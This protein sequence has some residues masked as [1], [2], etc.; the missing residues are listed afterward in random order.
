VLDRIAEVLPDCRHVRMEIAGHT[1]SQG[2]DEMNLNLSQSRANA[3]LNGLLARNVLVS[4]L[5]AQ[6]YGETQP[7]AS[8]ETESGREQ[9]RRIEFRLLSTASDET[10]ITQ[11]DVAAEAEAQAAPPTEQTGPRPVPRPARDSD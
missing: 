8:N 10:A 11:S 4:N 5:T 1:D 7:I 6:G 2:R 9:N 3:V